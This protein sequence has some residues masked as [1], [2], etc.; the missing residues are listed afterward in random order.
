MSQPGLRV[1]ICCPY[2]DAGNIKNQTI[3]DANV[4]AVFSAALELELMGFSPYPEIYYRSTMDRY[5]EQP[6]HQA[7]CVAKPQIQ[8]SDVMLCLRKGTVV[9]RDADLRE[10]FAKEFGVRVVYR[11]ADLKPRATC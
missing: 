9:C 7:W 11:I 6:T 10:N 5:R 2:T 3:V 8:G 4:Q 1:F